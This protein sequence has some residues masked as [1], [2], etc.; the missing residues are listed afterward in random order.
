MLDAFLRQN[1]A[2]AAQLVELFDTGRQLHKFEDTEFPEELEDQDPDYLSSIRAMIV[3]PFSLD[4]LLVG[5]SDVYERIRELETKREV[6]QNTWVPPTRFV[7][8]TTKFWV[9]PLDVTR[10]KC[11]VIK[12]LPISIFG[13][14]DNIVN[15]AGQ[16][17]NLQEADLCDWACISSLYFDDA[18]MQTYASR[19][20]KEDGAQVVRIRWYGERTDDPNFKVWVERK[21]HREPWTGDRSYKERC[22]IEQ[23]HAAAVLSGKVKAEEIARD[24]SDVAVLGS[25]QS[26]LSE[27]AQVP[28]MRTVCNRTAFQEK[29][30]ALIRISLD[31]QLHMIRELSA[32]HALGGW[33]R[34][35][36]NPC[37]DGDVVHFPFYVAEVKL[38]VD[39]PPQ[40][41]Q[42]LISGGLM[43]PAPRFSK[44][45]HGTASLFPDSV[46]GLP[47]WF[48][49]NHNGTY[50]PATW[51]E[52]AATEDP[53]EKEAAPW[54][55]PGMD[56][57]PL[58]ARLS[59]AF[60][61]RMWG[62]S[63]SA[64]PEK[65]LLRATPPAAPKQTITG[66][67][68]SGPGTPD[69][70]QEV[71]QRQ[72]SGTTLSATND[73][74]ISS[75]HHQDPPGS[76]LSSALEP[77]LALGQSTCTCATAH[78]A[79][80]EPR[81]GSASSAIAPAQICCNVRVLPTSRTLSCAIVEKEGPPLK[82]GQCKAKSVNHAE[83]TNISQGP[84][85]PLNGSSSQVDQAC[86]THSTS[87]YSEGASHQRDH[88]S[89]EMQHAAPATELDSS[90][91]P[92]ASESRCTRVTSS[93]KMEECSRTGDDGLHL[94]EA[95]SSGRSSSSSKGKGYI[96]VDILEDKT[97]VQRD[98]GDKQKIGGL[99]RFLP[100]RWKK[101]DT[102]LEK[103]PKSSSGVA[104]YRAKALVRTRVEPKTFFANERT[105]LAWLHI[106]VLIMFM[107]LSL[108]GGSTLTGS[109]PGLEGSSGSSS[110]SGSFNCRA[111]KYAGIII[112]PVAALFMVYAFYMYK[113]RTIQILRRSKVRYDDQRGPIM[114][115]ILLI[116]AT[117]TA[118]VITA[119]AALKEA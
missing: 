59:E 29:S 8:A 75:Y 66:Q 25:I 70:E 6:A 41:L 99:R 69:C 77:G 81:L 83:V 44:H 79:L 57:L 109:G 43:L 86:T 4:P 2:A 104:G 95:M 53:Y 115:V 49:N 31:G 15:G 107:A 91:A 47:Y 103:L 114:L 26:F 18:E 113:K 119:Q 61:R 98:N 68:T 96:V 5:L 102:P 88:L 84:S 56:Q 23:R 3:G 34:D 20:R 39:S 92:I 13:R 48:V 112:A 10:I 27:N 94:L 76:S 14:Q 11:E 40:W 33:C 46:E 97:A 62:R 71:E 45:L 28:V 54:M 106:S 118:F 35:M 105:F 80:S 111:A 85:L 67:N 108:L 116:V 38:Q 78:R 50:S 73:G 58:A 21:V 7:R 89:L 16:T 63:S 65:G 42:D 51:E 9:K 12:H 55:F 1:V 82:D 32:P 17:G 30:N 72:S 36:R 60:K 101:S 22:G 117:L 19:L 87:S 37:G 64:G 90:R 93:T 110:C 100:A 24:S 74:P 52:M